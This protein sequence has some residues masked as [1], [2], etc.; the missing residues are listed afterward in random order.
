MTDQGLLR[1]A[2]FKGLRD[3]IRVEP[4]DHRIGNPPAD[5]GTAQSF[6]DRDYAAA[7]QDDGGMA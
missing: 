7:L 3:I 2:V 4:S 5:G 6:S 1:E